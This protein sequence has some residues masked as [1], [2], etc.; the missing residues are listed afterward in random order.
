VADIVREKRPPF[1]DSKGQLLQIAEPAALQL[2]DVSGIEAA[3]PK[4]FRK[5]RPD[6]LID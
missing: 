3:L 6:I 5:Q 2:V 1:L 4:G